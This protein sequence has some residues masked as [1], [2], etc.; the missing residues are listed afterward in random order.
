MDNAQVLSISE[1]DFLYNIMN[2]K[3]EGAV[4][5]EEQLKLLRAGVN[6]QCKDKGPSLQASKKNRAISCTTLLHFSLFRNHRLLSQGACVLVPQRQFPNRALKLPM[7]SCTVILF[8]LWIPSLPQAPHSLIVKT[9]AQLICF[10]LDIVC[11]TG[12]LNSVLSSAPELALS[13]KRRR[14]IFI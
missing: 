11:T 5:P 10:I 4:S 13:L 3:V 2:L 9:G 8:T 12:I 7:P 14:E 1:A 6:I